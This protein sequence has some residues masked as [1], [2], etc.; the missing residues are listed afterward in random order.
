MATTPTPSRHSRIGRC[1]Q[2]VKTGEGALPLGNG[3]RGRVPILPKEGAGP[4]V[5]GK[6]PTGT[7]AW[8]CAGAS[9]HDPP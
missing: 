2:R 8:R 9:Y 7:A 4:L 6:G 1:E 5:D 3:A